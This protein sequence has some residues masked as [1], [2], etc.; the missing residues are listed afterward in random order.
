MTSRE[1]KELVFGGIAAL[2]AIALMTLLTIKSAVEGYS[3]VAISGAVAV[4]WSTGLLTEAYL[5]KFREERAKKERERT[6]IAH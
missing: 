1:K 6:K 2:V 3:L 5:R 4:L